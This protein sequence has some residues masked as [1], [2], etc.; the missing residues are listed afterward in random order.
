MK[1]L[2]NTSLLISFVGL[3]IAVLYLIAAIFPQ[4]FW[5]LH[6]IS[7]LT[8]PIQVLFFS[9]ALA[10]IVALY[11]LADRISLP[12]LD[13]KYLK[14][15]LF[16]ILSSLSGLGYY[17]FP[18]YKSLY[19]DSEVFRE[20]MGVRTTEY[21]ELFTNSLLSPNVL[22]P[23]IGNLTVLSAV[24][25]LSYNLDI[26]HQ[27][28]FKLI[29]AVS[30]IVFVLIWLLFINW[31]VENKLLKLL[32]YLIGLT[33]PFTQFFFGYEEIYAPAFPISA[34][35]LITIVA[36]F[37]S[38]NT[39]LLALL[40]IFLFLC[41]KIH[42][43][44]ILL[45]PS[46]GLTLAYHF[47]R[48]NPK[49]LSYFNWK[50]ISLG[51]ML[52]FFAFGAIAYFFILK[53]YNDPR[54]VGD[55][56]NIY[57]RLFLPLIPPAPPYDR[58]TL[59][60]FNHFFDCFNM[61][62]LW[63]SSAV[64]ILLIIVLFF[65]KRINWNTPEIIVTGFTMV[66]F[67]MIYFAYNPLMSMPVDFDLFSL[68]ATTLLVLSTVLITQLK[69]VSIEKHISGT[70]LALCFMS[71][72]LFIVNASGN[73]LGRRIESVG[74]YV[75]KTY[76]IKSSDYIIKGIN[77]SNYTSQEKA[78]HLHKITDELKPYAIEN[79]DVEYAN[80]LLELAKTYRNQLKDY[81]TALYHHRQALRYDQTTGAM[82]VGL[83]ESNFHL[84]NY[85]MALK[86]AQKLLEYN[87]P[88]PQSALSSA[89]SCAI[90]ADQNKVALVYCNAYLSYSANEHIASIRELLINGESLEE[91]K[92]E[93]TS[94]NSR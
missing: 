89:I 78:L 48:N 53:D 56:V 86:H 50:T 17:N 1:V 20:K 91:I 46:L 84:G 12:N 27:Q 41:L 11:F 58:Y 73:M 37:K 63:S 55:D 79:K 24:R 88:S 69:E 65:R 62:F 40:P 3:A 35:Y 44:F 92:A 74:R 33:A 13:N 49:L 7:F 70:V 82:Y 4:P 30:G 51:L 43:V 87:Y 32:L 2:R 25:L 34:L 83:M 5:G 47:V 21:Y 42:A 85:T 68:P 15:G 81:K 90:M 14:I 59:L 54:F 22:H 29:G 19:G 57:E 36:Y 75:F 10:S 66:L 76:W 80:L 23:K 60:H 38:K 61:V 39:W 26:T 28:A 93:L 31:Y 64:F 52:P 71:L 77:L 9:L 8:T 94:R 45:T 67:L 6:F 72:P 16:L 18:F